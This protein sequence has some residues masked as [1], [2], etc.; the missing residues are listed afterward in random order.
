MNGLVMEVDLLICI[1][2]LEGLVGQA[3][4]PYA[5]G[6]RE[7]RV[8]P[9]FHMGFHITIRMGHDWVRYRR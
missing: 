6:N 5:I 7:I 9:D 1:A 8:V 3:S 4:Q 2:N